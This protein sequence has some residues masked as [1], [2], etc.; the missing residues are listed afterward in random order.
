MFL[1]KYHC[2]ECGRDMYINE[3]PLDPVTCMVCDN[4]PTY[5]GE[6]ELFA[7]DELENKISEGALSADL[8]EQKL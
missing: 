2:T 8:E 3:T 4:I 1:Q 5:V 7:D 6:V